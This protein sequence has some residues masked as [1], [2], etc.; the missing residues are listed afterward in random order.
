MHALRRDLIEC[1]HK[2]TARLS[3]CICGSGT[4]MISSLTQVP[5]CSKTLIYAETIYSLPAIHRALGYTPKSVVSN[6]VARQLAQRAFYHNKAL[7]KPF[8][9]DISLNS[10]F[11]M[12]VGVTSAIQTNFKR[13]DK[14]RMHMC[15]WSAHVNPELGETTEDADQIEALRKANLHISVRDFYVEPPPGWDRYQQDDYIELVILYNIAKVIR[16]EC[17]C[18]DEIDS[19]LRMLSS[20]SFISTLGPAPSS[21]S[22]PLLDVASPSIFRVSATDR[23]AEAVQF[24]LDGKTSSVRFNEFGEIRCEVPPYTPEVHT[25]RKS[26]L[27]SSANPNDSRIKAENPIRLLFPGSFRPLHFG[28]TELARAALRALTRKRPEEEKAE[29]EERGGLYARTRITYEITVNI[30]D[31]G[32]VSCEDL[33]TRICQFLQ[34]G[35]RVAV[36]NASLFTE[37]AL[38]FPGVGFIVG[39][40]T[41]RRILDPRYYEG[42]D[43]VQALLDGIGKRGSYFIV[44]G[45]SVARKDPGKKG[46][47]V[48]WEDLRSL[49]IPDALRHLFIGLEESEFRIDISSTELRA[50]LGM[51]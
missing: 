9:G 38:L 47:Q 14:D 36:T 10:S 13:N 45:R 37:K 34:R 40:D 5:G 29:K 15:I 22:S 8:E 42:G 41:A 24:V 51:T 17:T 31:K 11:L 39:V 28:H 6:A 4:S 46:N 26:T 16:E 3:A 7:I 44:G 23:V 25:I 12:G 43:V 33:T 49:E 32:R 35:E 1:I 30:L 48:V 2:S 50:R 18:P 21:S 20:P 27:S 19:I